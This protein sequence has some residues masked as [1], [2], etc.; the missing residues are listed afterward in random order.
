M[1]ERSQVPPASAREK[2]ETV[3]KL[4]VLSAAL[5]LVPQLLW[6]WQPTQAAEQSLAPAM[7]GLVLF[8]ATYMVALLWRL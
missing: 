1:P 4:A 6:G 2:A 5:L 8:D 3:R 7:A